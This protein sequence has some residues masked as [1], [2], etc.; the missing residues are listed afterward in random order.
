VTERPSSGLFGRWPAQTPIRARLGLEAL[1]SSPSSMHSGKSAS[2]SEAT[3]PP[4][5]EAGFDE[6]R[7]FSL[8]RGSPTDRE[9]H[10]FGASGG[11]ASIADRIAWSKLQ[12]KMPASLVVATGWPLSWPSPP[13][14]SPWPPCSVRCGPPT[15]R[16]ARLVSMPDPGSDPP[17][18]LGVPTSSARPTPTR[19]TVWPGRTRGRL[20]HHPAPAPGGTGKAAFR[21]RRDGPDDTS[22]PCCGCGRRSRPGTRPTCPPRRRAL[23]E[24]YA[25]GVNHYAAAHPR[26]AWPGS[27]PVTGKDVIAGSCQRPL[28]LR[29]RQDAP[30]ADGPLRRAARLP[31]GRDRDRG[32]APRRRGRARVER[33][34]GGPP[35][36]GRRLHP[37]A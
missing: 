21:L 3:P 37:L 2:S 25:D 6:R 10:D 9:V 12:R 34:R 28:V 20:R 14:C 18:Y 31:Q 23:V 7:T 35:K 13:P 30:R 32:R 4:S 1:I 22:S 27:I 33:H 19:P 5:G 24:A 15:S 26:D 17:R 29:P 11:G 8:S 36:V 16:R